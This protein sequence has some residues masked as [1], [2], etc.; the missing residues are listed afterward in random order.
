MASTF[1][2]RGALID[3]Y[4]AHASLTLN[5]LKDAGFNDPNGEYFLSTVGVNSAFRAM[6]LNQIGG[7][8]EQFHYFL[9]ESDVCL[10]LYKAGWGATIAPFAEVHHAYAESSE[11]AA[12]RAPRGSVSDRR[13]PSLLRPD[14]R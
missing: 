5:D 14:P 7:F 2:G 13:Q 6:A 12:N 11:R 3:R 8:D 1:N 4:G 9:D 10:R